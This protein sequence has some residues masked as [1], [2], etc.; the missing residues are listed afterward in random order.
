MK[1]NEEKY[2]ENKIENMGNSPFLPTLKTVDMED[3]SFLQKS[4]I[5]Q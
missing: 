5:K 2:W 3:S 1:K 4:I